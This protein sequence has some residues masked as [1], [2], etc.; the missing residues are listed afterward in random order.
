MKI[1]GDLD[2][3]LIAKRTPGYVAADLHA[4]IKEAGNSAISRGISLNSLDLSN[5]YIE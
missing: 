1:R 4:L 2:T 5:L 3:M